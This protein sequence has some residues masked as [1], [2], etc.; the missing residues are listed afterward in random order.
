M[1][2]KEKGLT[3]KPPMR[4]LDAGVIC[5]IRREWGEIA[6]R[7]VLIAASLVLA[8]CLTAP[9]VTTQSLAASDNSV[10]TTAPT[11]LKKKVARPLKPTWQQCFDMSVDRGFNH[12]SEEWQQSIADCMGGKI[13]L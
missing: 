12:D 1:V 11:Q 9:N 2:V 5:A 3:Q 4:Q 10:S 13:P 6:M 8:V 7:F